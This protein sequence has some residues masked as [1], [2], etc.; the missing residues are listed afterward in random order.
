MI[1]FQSCHVGPIMAGT[2]TQ[3]RRIWKRQRCKV[4]SI[5]LAKTKMM[6]KDYF[7]RLKVRAVYQERLGDISEEDSYAEGYPSRFAYWKTFQK[8]N[9]ISDK[10]FFGMLN[11]IVWV[12]RFEVE[13]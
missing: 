3:T 9:K 12:V 2:K 8:I 6:S 10:D 5:H 1:L 7:A 4:G 11:T 13:C